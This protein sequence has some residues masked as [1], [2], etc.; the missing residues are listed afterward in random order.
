[1]CYCTRTNVGEGQVHVALKLRGIASKRMVIPDGAE[2][3]RQGTLRRVVGPALADSAYLLAAGTGA[4]LAFP[5]SDPLLRI[6]PTILRAT[7]RAAAEAARMP[8][9]VTVHSLRHYVASGLCS[10]AYVNPASSEAR[11][12]DVTLHSFSAAHT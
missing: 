7:C 11:M 6:E 8:K 9:H 1:V 4:G 5:G 3:G 12:L 10:V 2:Q